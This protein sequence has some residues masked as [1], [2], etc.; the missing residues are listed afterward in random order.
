MADMETDKEGKGKP[1]AA[2]PTTGPPF[3]LKKWNA[4]AMWQWDVECDTCAICRVQ[5]MGKWVWSIRRDNQSPKT[6]WFIWLVDYTVKPFVNSHLT[7][8]QAIPTAS[9]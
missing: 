2:K 9:I 4:V 7:R 8:S 1:K 5:V 3:T 6:S